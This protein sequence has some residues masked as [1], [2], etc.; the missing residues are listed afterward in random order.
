MK[1]LNVLCLLL[2]I[3]NI[4]VAQDVPCCENECDNISIYGNADDN[5]PTQIKHNDGFTYLS[6][7]VSING[8]LFATVTKFDNNNNV[9]WEY[10]F[11]SP[12][13]IADFIVVDNGLLLVGRTEPAIVSGTNFDNELLIARIDNDGTPIFIRTYDNTARE[14]FLRVIEHTN[15]PNPAFPFYAT[16]FENNTSFPSAD[17]DAR[18]YNIDNQGNINWVVEYAF[19]MVD[20]QI[21]VAISPTSDGNLLLGGRGRNVDGLIAKVNGATG[22]ILSSEDASIGVFHNHAHELSNGN[23]VISGFLDVSTREILLSLFDSDLNLL[24]SIRLDNLFGVFLAAADID[25][26]DDFYIVGMQSQSNGQPVLC[27]ISTANNT[28]TLLASKY[29]NNG[30]TSFGGFALDVNGNQIYYADGRTGNPLSTGGRD[31]LLGYFDT[32]LADDCFMDASVTSSVENYTLSPF[33]ITSVNVTPAT[34]LEN[35][36]LI[37]QQ[38]YNTEPLCDQSLCPPTNPETV[39][40]LNEWGL[41]ILSLLLLIIGFVGIRDRKLSASNYL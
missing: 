23:I 29:F 21:G 22:Q 8:Q 31:V 40:T 20:E 9:I 39:P 38:P 18:L 17:D 7:R 37:A 14:L 15:P 6:G 24:N 10:Q 34:P 19:E 3:L 33:S 27:K 30:E 1:E 13:N 35:I 16:T 4:T 36:G 32:E 28:L 5:T 12:S 26:N 11:D 41:I 25:N 2:F